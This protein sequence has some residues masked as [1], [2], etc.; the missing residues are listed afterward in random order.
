MKSKNVGSAAKYAAIGLVGVTLAV[1]AAEGVLSERTRG[2][3]PVLAAT[4][5]ARSD[6]SSPES[7]GAPASTA[8]SVSSA[9]SAAASVSAASAPQSSSSADGGEYSE[10]PLSYSDDEWYEPPAPVETTE[11]TA[12][13]QSFPEEEQSVDTP[14]SSEPREAPDD[15]DPQVEQPISEPQSELPVSDMSPEQSE[16][17]PAQ[18]A[19][20]P[21]QTVPPAFSVAIPETIVVNINTAGVEELIT[22]DGIGEDKALAIIEFRE[23]FGGFTS[24]YEIREVNGIGDS[25]FERI[26]DFIVI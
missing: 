13:E 10:P 21:V 18:S 19:E 26:R 1:A 16:P 9:S 6:R 22:L 2:D 20:P 4:S 25:T 23:T 12:P 24:I 5:A 3:V 17:P 14:T 11:Q 8:Q 7:S 15:N